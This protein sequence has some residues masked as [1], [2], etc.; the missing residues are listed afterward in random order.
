HHLEKVFAPALEPFLF[1]ADLRAV[2]GDPIA[3]LGRTELFEPTLEVL[4]VEKDRRSVD[5]VRDLLL[6]HPIPGDTWGH[7]RS[8]RRLIP[9]ARRYSVHALVH[10]SLSPRSCITGRIA[11]SPAA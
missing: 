10:R 3:E 5:K 4:P 1:A 6:K 11:G 7:L 2:G 9:G 8:V